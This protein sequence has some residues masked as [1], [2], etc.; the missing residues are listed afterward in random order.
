MSEPDSQT[1]APV[2]ILIAEDDAEMLELLSRVLREEGFRVLTA[3]DGHQALV[4]IEEGDFDLV[5]SD[6]RMPGPDGMEVLRRAVS[7]LTSQ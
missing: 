7:Q 2:R 6:V 5:L 3:S 4:R 1:A